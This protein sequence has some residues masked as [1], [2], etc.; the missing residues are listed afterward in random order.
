MTGIKAAR[1]TRL[2][3]LLS[4]KLADKI[5][6][7][8]FCREYERAYNLEVREGELT[9]ED[10]AVFEELFDIVAWFTADD[11]ARSELPTHFKDEAA[12]EAAAHRAHQK[13]A[14]T[15]SAKKGDDEPPKK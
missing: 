6:Y 5:S 13:L 11:S 12:V 1:S 9:V 10:E 15:T 8:E 3:D 7:E 2:H 14:E 4:L